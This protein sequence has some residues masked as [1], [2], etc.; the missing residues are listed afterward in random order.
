M[1]GSGLR[2]RAWRALRFALALSPFVPTTSARADEMDVCVDAAEKS[3]SLRSHGRLLEARAALVV[4]A[5]ASCPAEV[6]QT[7]DERLVKVTQE[8]PSILFGVRDA[9]GK[10][11]SAVKLTI[12]G[13]LAAE[14][15]TGVPIAIDPGDHEFKFEVAG[16][17]PV[18]KHFVILEGAQSRREEIVVGAPPLPE[19]TAERPH[20]RPLSTPRVLAVV[21]G[22]VGLAAIAA[23]AITGEL[24][25]SHADATKSNCPFDGTKDRCNAS[26]LNDMNQAKGLALASDVS[27]GV[28]A[29]G[30][31][32]AV[33]LWVVGA[34]HAPPATGFSDP[35]SWYWGI[36]ATPR[37]SGGF[38]GHAF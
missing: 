19:T 1:I 29:L 34:P 12:D 35:K 8:I 17:A 23:G 4:C 37:G 13:A 33:V 30:V 36:T 11:L 38:L 24:A 22:G 28:G 25:I 7:C 2:A 3:L 21:S 31:I 14:Q 9:S 26:A 15:L 5:A 32:G 18:V 16:E 10:D 27:F 20:G 6:R